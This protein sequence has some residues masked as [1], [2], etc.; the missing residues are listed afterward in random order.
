MEAGQIGSHGV[1]ALF[2]VEEDNRNDQELAPI[3]RRPLKERHV[4]GRAKK[5]SRAT[6]NPA[7]VIFYFIFSLVSKIIQKSTFIGVT[8]F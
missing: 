5:P 2:L 1:T 6:R 8:L 4:L 7:Q 3:P